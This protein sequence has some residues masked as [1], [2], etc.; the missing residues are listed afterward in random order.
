[1]PK[2]KTIKIGTYALGCLEVKLDADLGVEGG[3]FNLRPS[4]HVVVGL[5]YHPWHEVV[6]I[7]LHEAFEISMV[8][9][10]HKQRRVPIVNFDTGDCT[11]IFNHPDFARVC[12]EAGAFMADS[13]PDLADVYNKN[14]NKKGK[15]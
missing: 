14:C 12:A 7:L 9:H 1:M 8:I 6:A 11:F 5:K 4:P 3:Y 13:L 10:G 15:K 2:N